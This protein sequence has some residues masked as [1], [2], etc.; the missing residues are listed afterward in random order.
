MRNELEAFL[1]SLR[2]SGYSEHT[3]DA[4]RRDLSEFLGN[5][6][7]S[8]SE[9]SVKNHVKFLLEKG[10]SKSTVSRKLSSIRSF[11]RFLV[12][13]KRSQKSNH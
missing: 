9:K 6:K 2:A 13:T 12:K 11:M 8:L 7:D 3:I 1:E 5:L 4:Y 10:N